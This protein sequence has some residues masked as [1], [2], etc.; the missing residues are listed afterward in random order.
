MPMTFLGTNCNIDIEGLALLP[1]H[2]LVASSQGNFSY[3]IFDLKK[4]QYLTS[5][6]IRPG[7]VDGAEETDGIEIISQ[8][9]GFKFPQGVLVVQDGYNTDRDKLRNQNFKV[10]DLKNVISLIK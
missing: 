3:A 7:A 10:V 5:F 2:Y 6:I 8:N 4:Q 1:P 9:L